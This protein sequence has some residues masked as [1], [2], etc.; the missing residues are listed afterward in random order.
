M[1][2]TVSTAGRGAGGAAAAAVA[3]AG[4]ADR[5]KQFLRWCYRGPPLLGTRADVFVKWSK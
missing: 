4:D 2:F 5:L 1:L 3:V